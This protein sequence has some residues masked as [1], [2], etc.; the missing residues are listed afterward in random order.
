MSARSLRARLSWSRS[1]GAYTSDCMSHHV[2]LQPH[3]YCCELDDGLVFLDVLQGKYSALN[4]AQLRNV[5]PL[6]AVSTSPSENST[7]YN[8]PAETLHRAEQLIA[9]GMF[10]RDE[11]R[12]KPVLPVELEQ[13]DAVDFQGAVSD[14]PR[15][16]FRD[17]AYMLAAVTYA[18]LQ[19]KL[20]S[21]ERI[22][23]HF[24]QHA[25]LP[26]KQI[27]TLHARQV[28]PLVNVFRRLRSFFYTAEGHCLLDSL[29]LMHFLRC[30]GMK[31]TW[32]I[33]VA[34][35]PFGAHSWVQ[36]GD[37]VLNDTL[38]HARKFKPILVL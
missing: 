29:V 15:I 2:Y 24:E 23:A 11:K 16:G 27:V 14:E 10:T 22:V 9:S 31:A 33:G 34:T 25:R 5:R 26:P 6:L 32:A 12:G 7:A 18:A 8:D 19:L 30:Y 21:F 36:Y 35:R 1:R 38:D 20:C 28:E 17:F 37:V 4:A 13:S 3:V